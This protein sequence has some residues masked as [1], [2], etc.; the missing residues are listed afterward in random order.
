[1]FDINSVF[2]DNFDIISL[3]FV[4]IFIKKILYLA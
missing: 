2:V 1:M 4:F 3:D